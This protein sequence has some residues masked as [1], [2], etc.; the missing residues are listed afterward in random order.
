MNDRS[1]FSL[2]ELVI[3][4]LI[5]TVGLLG[6]AGATAF[7]LRSATASEIST[8]RTAALQGALEEIRSRPFE[9]IATGSRTAGPHTVEWE[10]DPSGITE[11]RTKLVTVVIT[12]PG[13]VQ[14]ASGR[15]PV[16]S[17]TVT[18]TFTYRLIRRTDS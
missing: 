5:L 13:R 12:G 9:T 11:A 17:T 7:V 8:Q 14:G 3:A 18:D 15:M 1:G 10:A 2:V 4:M 16:L 6:M